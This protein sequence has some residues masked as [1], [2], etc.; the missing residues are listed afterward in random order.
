M[1]SSDL[2]TAASTAAVTAPTTATDFVGHWGA[3]LQGWRDTPYRNHRE[4]HDAYV[5]RTRKVAR[6][7]GAPLLDARREFEGKPGTMMDDRIHLTPAGHALMA[8]LLAGKIASEVVA[9]SQGESLHIQ[10][11]VDGGR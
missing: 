9:R 6:E 5:E 2:V 3:M 8:N 4:I 10:P 7:T 1:C 11:P